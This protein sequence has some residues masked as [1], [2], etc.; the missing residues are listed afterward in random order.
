VALAVGGALPGPGAV[1]LALAIAI[2]VACVVGRYHYI[3][4]VVAGAAVAAALWLAN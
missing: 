3:V 1:L 2:C 4:D